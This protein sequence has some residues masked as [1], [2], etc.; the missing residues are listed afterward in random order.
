[1][2]ETNYLIYLF[3][4][5]HNVSADVLHYLTSGCVRDNVRR[6]SPSFH[7]LTFSFSLFSSRLQRQLLASSN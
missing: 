5:V 1:M 6:E 2:G 4:H 3:V 7:V